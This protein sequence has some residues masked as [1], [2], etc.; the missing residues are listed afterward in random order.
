MEPQPTRP[1]SYLP[2]PR[3]FLR[4]ILAYLPKRT[5]F[6]LANNL[7]RLYPAAA[8]FLHSSI[9]PAPAP[10]PAPVLS[11][12]FSSPSIAPPIPVTD[13]DSSIMAQ[14]IA[15][16]VESLYTPIAQSNEDSRAQN[17]YTREEMS[18]T[19]PQSPPLPP[20]SPP[21]RLRK[22]AKSMSPDRQGETLRNALFA[23]SPPSSPR[24]PHSPPL[25]PTLI[26][27]GVGANNA[28][29]VHPMHR[30][31]L[32]YDEPLQALLNFYDIPTVSY[33]TVM[34][35]FLNGVDDNVDLSDDTMVATPNASPGRARRS[36]RRS[37]EGLPSPS[38]PAAFVF[39]NKS[40]PIPDYFSC[41]EECTSLL[42][43]E[44]E[45]KHVYANGDEKN[46]IPTS[47]AASP[48]AQERHPHSPQ[49]TS[50]LLPT[51]SRHSGVEDSAVLCAHTGES[52]Q[53]QE[54][55]DSKWASSSISQDNTGTMSQS[56]Q[57]GDRRTSSQTPSFEETRREAEV[58]NS[59][60]CGG[61]V[62]PQTVPKF[63]FPLGK[64]ISLADRAAEREA[65]LRAVHAVYDNRPFLHEAH[66]TAVT[67]ACEL[68]RYLNLALFRR[69]DEMGAKDEKITF[70]QFSNAWTSLT[71]DNYDEYSLIFALLKR[72][73][74]IALV[75]ED[76]LHV[77]EACYSSTVLFRLARLNSWPVETLDVVCNHP[78]L[79]F[80]ADNA[81]FQERYVETV[82]CR[83]FY[84]NRS[85]SGKITLPQFKRSGFVSMLRRLEQG[86]DLNLTHDCFSYKHFYVIYCKFWEL[87]QDHDLFISEEDLAKYG[88]Y[89]L[90]RRTI[91]RVF[92][93]GK[94][95]Y[96]A[97]RGRNTPSEESKMSYLDFIWFL[98]SEVDKQSPTSIEYW[99][100]CLDIDGDG[101]ISTYELAYFY[102][103]QA[104][105]QIMFD[106]PEHDR[107]KFEDAICQACYFF[108]LHYIIVS[109]NDLVKPAV[110]GQFTL[111]DLKRCKMAERFIDMFTNLSKLQ[112][113]ESSHNSSRLKRQFMLAQRAE[114]LEAEGGT[115]ILTMPDIMTM[116]D[117]DPLRLGFIHQILGSLIIKCGCKIPI[118]TKLFYPFFPSTSEWCSY[119]E[120][121]Y[122]ALVLTERS[123]EEIDDVD[124]DE[125]HDD[126]SPKEITLN[127]IEDPGMGTADGPMREMVLE[128]VST[129]VQ[130]VN[131]DL[132]PI[133]AYTKVE[134]PI[135]NSGDIEISEVFISSIGADD[136][137]GRIK[138]WEGAMDRVQR[139]SVR[140]EQQAM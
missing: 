68:P 86:I 134:R 18:S 92:C 82:I 98:L 87:D 120:F 44:K 39:E 15:I 84:D 119:A 91:H 71:K 113:H 96:E 124:P 48:A 64:S 60:G 127:P 81:L 128:R 16:P 53:Q 49:K 106:V 30:K 94:V 26:P 116:P 13:L 125:L 52:N 59:L 46:A 58:G 29:S 61:F 79:E 8:H 100:R 76:F 89:A 35:P 36:L 6:F 137:D 10:A 109:R 118:L 24:D 25:S 37:T 20:G 108:Q 27:L 75:P 139:R 132:E 34:S 42:A 54:K 90:T 21:P 77:L 78:G 2:L 19:P 131:D 107:L 93:F 130:T 105:R 38:L 104:Q 114:L 56:P 3:F 45:M 66:F 88:G 101:L 83:I 123:Q 50:H 70:E 9:A 95:N 33:G 80:L 85:M 69:I 140:A 41:K 47:P 7:E 112:M 17:H 62:V 31:K 63:F 32:S 133:Y 74:A 126:S 12:N 5:T 23:S 117:G 57:A 136:N 40:F 72:P 97:R 22:R 138:E 110:I 73:Q 111:Q 43:H 129:V 1:A 102:E 51:L 99:F 4:H 14:P 28:D 115:P 135:A 67:K 65:I 103:E 11:P 122:Q 55:G 121:E